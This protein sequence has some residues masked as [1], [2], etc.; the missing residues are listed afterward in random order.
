MKERFLIKAVL[1]M[2]LVLLPVQAWAATVNKMRYSSSPTKVRIVLDVDDKVQFRDSKQGQSIVVDIDAKAA[3]EFKESVKDPIIKNVVLKK[4]KDNKS[5]LVIDLNKTQ[6]YKV[7]AL[8]EPNRIVVDIYRIIVSKTSYEQGQGLK[9]TFWQD[10]MN[11]LPVQMYILEMSPS[12]KYNALPFSAAI[13]KNGRG[14]LLRATNVLK[15]KAAVNASYFDTSGWII[16]NLKIDG[17]WLGM[18]DT[19]RSAFIIADKKPQIVK[20]LAYKGEVTFEKLGSSIRVKGINRERIAEDFVIY[21]HYFG[22][23]TRTNAFGIEARIKNGKITEISKAGNMKLDKTSVV[24]SGHGMNA[25]II[26]QLR[27]GDK[28][29]LEQTL[30][31]S[32]AD[33]AEIVLGAGPLLVEDGRVNV[34]S[35]SEKMAGDIAYGRAPRTAIGV[36]KD[37]SIILMVVD[38]RSTSSSGMSLNELA[39]YMVKLGAVSALNFD[40]GGSSE[41]VLNGKIV[42]NPSDGNERAVS[43]GMGIFAS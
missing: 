11:G 27:I 22:D 13:N 36:K 21:T 1:T 6:Q 32:L 28:V 4:E 3:K 10:D 37:G 7:F 43:V 19:P 30:G 25:K 26:E 33:K 14:T 35:T 12:S 18:E 24:I 42:N 38:G 34:R 2:L 31:S 9:Y 41:M 15:A 23:A 40:G 39:S 20:D 16:G 17:E 5:K 29:K 8:K